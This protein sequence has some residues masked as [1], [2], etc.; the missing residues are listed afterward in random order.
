MINQF[1]YIG[2][3]FFLLQTNFFIVSFAFTVL[4]FFRY[5][6]CLF[7]A[8]M[9]SAPLIRLNEDTCHVIDE[10]INMFLE[11]HLPREISAWEEDTSYVWMTMV[12]L[13]HLA[14]AAGIE[15]HLD[16]KV[17]GSQQLAS[18]HVESTEQCEPM[19]TLGMYEQA[20]QVALSPP[21][22]L[23]WEH[24]QASNC[25]AQQEPLSCA[26][27]GTV[28]GRWEYKCQQTSEVLNSSPHNRQRC[29]SA[30]QGTN[31]RRPG[32]KSTQNLGIF[33]LVHMLSIKENQELALLENLVDYLVCLSWQL[34]SHNAKYI[35]L[36]LSNFK[37]V[38]PPSLKVITKSVLARLSGL[39]MVYHR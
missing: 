6:C 20:T 3:F 33:A 24:S 22:S 18:E 4:L 8:R 2:F 30:L 17:N 14:F 9:R 31:F 10:L 38:S 13:F 36:S 5:Y 37:T 27:S 7:L 23:G 32:S 29:A 16:S 21:E 26:V 39:D 12:P 11:K 15:S 25:L 34:N 1:Q 19:L 35:R 28:Q